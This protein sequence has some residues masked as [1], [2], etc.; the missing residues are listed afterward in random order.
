M[1]RRKIDKERDAKL[2]EEYVEKAEKEKTRVS[3]ETAE[4]LK[5]WFGKKHKCNWEKQEGR[6]L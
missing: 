5:A 1:Y 3:V 4:K 6:A 2:V